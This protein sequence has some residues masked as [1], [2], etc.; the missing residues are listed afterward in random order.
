MEKE[1]VLKKA[2]ENASENWGGLNEE[3]YVELVSTCG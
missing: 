2:S 1:K 3:K